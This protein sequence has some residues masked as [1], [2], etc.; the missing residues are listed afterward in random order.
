MSLCIYIYIFLT[1]NA[2]LMF[3]TF[4]LET[5]HALWEEWD[6]W[7]TCSTSCGP[8]LRTRDRVC[9][10]DGGCGGQTTQTEACGTDNVCP[11]K[12]IV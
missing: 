12:F 8:G 7:S 3:D 10:A 5:E 9:T 6:S 11:C 4:V 2:I 1:N